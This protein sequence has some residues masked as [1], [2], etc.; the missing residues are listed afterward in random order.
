MLLLFDYFDHRCLVQLNFWSLVRRKTTKN[1]NK[2]QKETDHDYSLFFFCLEL[3]TKSNASLL[4]EE[5]SHL[6]VVVFV[7]VFFLSSKFIELTLL[8]KRAFAHYIL[9]RLASLLHAST[10][11]K[12]TRQLTYNYIYLFVQFGYPTQMVDSANLHKYYMN[13]LCCVAIVVVIF[14]SSSSSS[15][16][17]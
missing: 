16:S 15:S 13:N 2:D 17:S 4:W 5:C 10:Y 6:V 1:K 8:Y 12:T 9:S 14:F 11:L 7:V 3:A